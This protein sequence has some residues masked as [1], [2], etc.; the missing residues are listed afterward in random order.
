MTLLF[1]HVRSESEMIAVDV[2]F[3]FLLSQS[4]R[5]PTVMNDN[6]ARY[7]TTKVRNNPRESW[8]R[9][10]GAKIDCVSSL[11]RRKI[12]SRRRCE[13]REIFTVA[14][15]VYEWKRASVF[16]D[17]NDVRATATKLSKIMSRQS[18]I[19][20]LFCWKI[21]ERGD[22]GLISSHSWRNWMTFRPLRL[23]RLPLALLTVDLFKAKKAERSAQLQSEN[24]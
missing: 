10:A 8:D 9:S 24:K 14:E 13:S 16:A 12:F 15:N 4:H 7:K 6:S 22:E 1:A 5:Q 17:K 21:T 20:V 3:D 2:K 19:F 18:Y 11:S 23:P